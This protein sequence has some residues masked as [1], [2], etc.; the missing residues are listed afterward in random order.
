MSEQN[1]TQKQEPGAC[2]PGCCCGTS[3]SGSRTR[4][5]AGIVILLVA[6]A[7]VARAMVKG[8]D[9]QA[10]AA[11]AGFASLPAP[12]QTPKS[13]AAAKPAVTGAIKEIAALSELNTVAADALGVFVFLPGK[14]ETSAKAP[15]AQIG[16]A[17]RT[18]EPQLNGGK[19]GIFALKTG[20]RDYEQMASQTT[21]PCVL[22]LVKGKGMSAT[23][24]EITETKLVQ[25]FVAAS[26][27]GS[28]G[29]VG[30]GPSSGG[31]K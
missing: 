17:A 20:S 28:C 21:V 31:C 10:N 30:C 23:S 14:G 25:A 29:P 9:T 24:G 1:D 7:L 2:G 3:G 13:D 6:G 18:M 22:A 4:W 26:S 27:T 12:A 19:I 8:S 16:S 5:I 11:T 15:T